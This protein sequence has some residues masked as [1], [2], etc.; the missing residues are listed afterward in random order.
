MPGI[1]GL[2]GR[3]G[4]KGEPGDRGE[5]GARVCRWLCTKRYYHSLVYIAKIGKQRSSWFSG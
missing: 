4:S 1:P 3:N 5:P 2:P